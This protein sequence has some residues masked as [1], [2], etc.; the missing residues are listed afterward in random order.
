MAE[1]LANEPPVRIGI[2]GGGAMGRKHAETIGREAA[3][4][5]V[6]VAD[7]ASRELAE[8]RNVPLSPVT[9]HCWQPAKWTR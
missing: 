5:L 9:A 2:I 6:A 7:P 8:M 4:Q 1:T 3:A